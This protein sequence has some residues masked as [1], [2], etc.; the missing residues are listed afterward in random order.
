MEPFFLPVVLASPNVKKHWRV[1]YN[2]SRNQKHMVAWHFI[3]HP[4]NVKLPCVVEMIR[5]GKKKMDGDNLQMALKHVRDAIASHLRPGM[6]PGQA[7][8]DESIILFK[9]DQVIDQDRK[10]VKII[11]IS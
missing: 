6:A 2:L 1:D 3:M 7:D 11:F 5:F 9:Y 10:G 8:N 4:P